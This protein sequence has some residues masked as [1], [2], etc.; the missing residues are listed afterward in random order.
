MFS[1]EKIEEL[2]KVVWEIMGHRLVQAVF[3]DTMTGAVID[4]VFDNNCKITIC[5]DYRGCK[6]DI[7]CPDKGEK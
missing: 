4:F 7:E 3:T 5:M 2:K 6:V 1:K